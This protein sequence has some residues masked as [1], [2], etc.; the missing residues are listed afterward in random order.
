MEILSGSD[1]PRFV[2]SERL[3]LSFL[4]LSFLLLSFRSSSPLR[5]VLISFSAHSSL[6][7]LST[8][9]VALFLRSSSSSLAPLKGVVRHAERP[10]APERLC[11]RSSADRHRGK[12]I[13]MSFVD[14]TS[15]SIHAR[16]GRRV[17]EAL[18]IYQIERRRLFYL[19]ST[20]SSR[21]LSVSSHYPHTLYTRRCPILKQ[22]NTM[23]LL[24]AL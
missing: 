19:L 22:S 23:R 10:T 14:E 6:F 4:L 7:L 9:V 5:V 18:N 12:H 16:R 20:P 3:F 15:F 1:T 11:F 2:S 21:N 13:N 8:F 17:A 24:R